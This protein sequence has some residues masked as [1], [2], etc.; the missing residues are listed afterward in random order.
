MPDYAALVM[1]ACFGVAVILAVIRAEPKDLPAIIRA[2]MRTDR[3]DD[4]RK[5]PPSL[6]EP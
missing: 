2:L 3:D 5:D 6:P 1:V 4:N